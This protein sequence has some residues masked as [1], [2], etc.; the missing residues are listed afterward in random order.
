MTK[1]SAV[2]KK[3]AGAWRR[4]RLPAKLVVVSWRDLAVIV[5]PVLLFIA[6]VVW[7]SFRYV[8]PCASRAT[9]TIVI[10]SGP[11]GSSFRTTADKYR[12]II[13]RSGVKV[14]ILTSQGGLDNLQKLA[15]PGTRSRRR[16]RSPISFSYCAAT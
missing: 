8:R 7:V 14:K 4:M 6:L 10:A 3:K 5:L 1:D 2:D 16:C 12:K 9:R 13:E 11:E 15:N